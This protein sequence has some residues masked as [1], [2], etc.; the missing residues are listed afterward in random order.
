MKRPLS[1][2]ARMTYPGRLIA[3]GRD[4]SGAFNIVIYAITGRSPSS[5]A[6][7]LVSEGNAVWTKPTDPAVLKKGNPDLLVYPALMMGGGIAVSNGK[8]TADIRAAEEGSPVLVLD[9]ALKNW[10][11]EPDD[12][13]FT[14]RI[15]GCV[16]PSNRAALSLIRR[17]SGGAALRSFFEF[18]LTPGLGKFVATYRGENE[19]PL[20]SYQG[21]PLALEIKDETPEAMAEAVYDALG[22]KHGGTDFRVAVA[23]VFAPAAD[24]KAYR[25]HI[26]NRRERTGP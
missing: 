10:S 16:L 23:C 20:P 8:Q 18:S 4:A 2:L 1:A 24:M 21:D 7:K 25:L 22:P 19:D 17:G 6:R 15:S 12:P 5:Q 13:I 14:P 26:I 11:F 3:L 9:S